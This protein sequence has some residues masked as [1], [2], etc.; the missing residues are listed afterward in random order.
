MAVFL[1]LAFAFVNGVETGKRKRPLRNNLMPLLSVGR[2]ARRRRRR[3]HSSNSSSGSRSSYNSLR[4]SCEIFRSP[5]R[6]SHFEFN[7]TVHQTVRRRRGGS[8]L[9]PC[10]PSL[11]ATR[12]T[13]ATTT[14]RSQRVVR[15]PSSIFPSLPS[16][17]LILLFFFFAF[18]RRGRLI[19]RTAYISICTS[20][21]L[22]R[23]EAQTE[24]YNISG[25]PP[26]YTED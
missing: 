18:L 2:V 7:L 17:A 12:A 15:T 10:L 13:T 9:C 20:R 1:D 22:T 5:R 25:I 8:L 26:E 21:S 6:C 3:H 19:R 11:P 14:T 23:A 24:K 16:P 4:G